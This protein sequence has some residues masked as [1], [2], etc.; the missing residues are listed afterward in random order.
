MKD[1][2]ELNYRSYYISAIYWVIT[3]FTSVGYGDIHG[4]TQTEYLFTIGIDML[5][6][7]FY[8][9]MIGVF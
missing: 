5:G 9:Y 1:M 4:S 6:I 8:G 2:Q 7:A 3:T